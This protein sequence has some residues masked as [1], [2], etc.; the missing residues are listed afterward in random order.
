[1]SSGLRQRI[2]GAL[3]LGALGLI[4]LPILFDFDDPLKIDHSSRLPAAPEIAP[5]EVNKAQRPEKAE[6]S[7]V[8]DTLF[9]IAKSAPANESSD[10]SRGLDENNLPQAWVLQVGS[11]EVADKADNLMQ[12]LR[13]GGFKSFVKAAAVDS[14]TYYR[15]YVGP[16]ADKRRATEEKQKIDLAF[17]TDAI[18]LQY[19]P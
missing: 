16:K 10:V 13:D 18:V 9:D 12:Q 14:K 2:V 5:V 15:V 3:V 4:I 17:K 1:M 8:L 6:E 19:V 7:G 11:F